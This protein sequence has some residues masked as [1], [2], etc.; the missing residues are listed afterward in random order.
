MQQNKG[1]TLMTN[2]EKIVVVTRPFVGKALTAKQVIALVLATYPETN[3]ASIMVSDHAGA[4][5]KGV[6]YCS[7]VFDRVATGYLVRDAVI[8]KAS[9]TRSKV[10]MADALAQANALLQGNV[11]QGQVVPPA[12]PTD[13]LVSLEA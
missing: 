10:S 1:V 2:T 6:T 12:M 8:P 9:K 13:E 4:N 7:Q 5:S 3:P 11:A